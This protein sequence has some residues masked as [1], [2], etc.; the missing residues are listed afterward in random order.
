MSNL[1]AI[2]QNEK[3]CIANCILR[4]P[5]FHYKTWQYQ[6]NENAF[7]YLYFP[8]NKKSQPTSAQYCCLAG[9]NTSIIVIVKT[10]IRSRNMYLNLFYVTDFTIKHY[11]GRCKDI[12]NHEASWGLSVC[13]LVLSQILCQQFIF[14]LCPEMFYPNLEIIV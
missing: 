5:V 2:S 11:S 14:A 13:V 12:A 10:K 8:R 9:K 6:V 7:L 3:N 4:Y 1:I